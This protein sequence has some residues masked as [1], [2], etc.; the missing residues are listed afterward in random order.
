M[1]V[2]SI[3]DLNISYSMIIELPF[4][5]QVTSLN[6]KRFGDIGR[7]GDSLKQQIKLEKLLVSNNSIEDDSI[8]NLIH[9]H[10]LDIQQCFNITTLA[11]KYLINI[12]TLN[13]IRS[14]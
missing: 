4:C 12:H 7:M 6:V 9:L 8:N 2:D 11:F 13:I 10:T 3:V 5:P 14:T 1:C